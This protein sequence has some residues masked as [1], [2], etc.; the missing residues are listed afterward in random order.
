MKYALLASWVGPKRMARSAG[1]KGNVLMAMLA[2]IF[3]GLASAQATRT[4]V[5]SV[6]DDANPCSRTAPCKTFAGAI[7]KTAAGGEINCLDPGGFGAVNITKSIT[8]DCGRASAF[9]WGTTG[10]VNVS[11]TSAVVMIRNLDINGLLAVSTPSANGIDLARLK[12]EWEEINFGLNPLVQVV[13]PQASCTWVSGVSDD[14]NPCSRTAPCKTSAGVISATAYGGK[15]N[16]AEPSGFGVVPI[17]KAININCEFP[18]DAYV[19]AISD[20]TRTTNAYT[21]TLS[22][23]NRFISTTVT[24]TVTISRSNFTTGGIYPGTVMV[25]GTTTP[26]SGDLNVSSSGFRLAPLTVTVTAETITVTLT[27]TITP[28]LVISRFISLTGT[29]SRAPSFT[30]TTDIA[31]VSVGDIICVRRNY[32]VIVRRSRV[33]RTCGCN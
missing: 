28:S 21:I 1:L 32:Q 15:I 11:A 26:T 23:V 10:V 31:A 17:T 29:A 30:A 9:V 22:S 4:W 3:A 24:F 2:L 18:A 25:G 7:S 33:A 16:W 20:I 13:S 27:D 8:I 12:D 5:F 19:V 14:A 6:G